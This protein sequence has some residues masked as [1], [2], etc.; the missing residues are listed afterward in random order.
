MNSSFFLTNYAQLMR[1]TPIS[2]SSKFWNKYF[3]YSI[4]NQFTQQ[5]MKFI[6]NSDVYCKNP[7]YKTYQYYIM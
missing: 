1:I 4:V 6:Q 7:Q 3:N 5:F 2:Q